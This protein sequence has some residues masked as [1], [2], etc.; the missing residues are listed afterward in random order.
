LSEAKTVL[1]GNVKDMQELKQLSDELLYEAGNGKKS[2][3]SSSVDIHKITH[4]AINSLATIARKNEMTINNDTDATIIETDGDKLEK[5][6]IILIENAI[7]Y[8]SSNS[9]IKVSSKHNK[10]KT[11]ITVS[12]HGI[13]IDRADVDKIFDRFYRAHRTASKTTGYGLGLSIA[14][15]LLDEIGAT[16]KVKS[17]IGVGSEFKISIPNRVSG[18]TPSSKNS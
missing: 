10:S 7:K 5:I 15:K 4:S 17:D 13:G 1:T 14:K 18:D 11:E 2:F 12:D 8:S 16:I 9:T 3:E 6:L